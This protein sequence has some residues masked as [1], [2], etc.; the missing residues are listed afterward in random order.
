MAHSSD[1]WE[2]SNWVD[3]PVRAILRVECSDGEQ[4]GW[5]ALSD[6]WGSLPSVSLVGM[7]HFGVLHLEQP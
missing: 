4:L 7:V 2:H 3:I 6:Q 5:G 1:N